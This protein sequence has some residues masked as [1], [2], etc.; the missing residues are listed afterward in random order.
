MSK[1]VLIA[2]G[3][4]LLAAPALAFDGSRKG[5]ILGVGAGGGATSF[6]QE[7][8]GF[9]T[10]K[11]ETET[12][13]AFATDFELGWG[14]NDQLLIYYSNHV[15]WFGITNVFN[16]SVT[17]AS[18][19]SSAAV[20]YFFKPAAPSAVVEGGIGGAGWNALS[21]GQSSSSVGLGVWAGGGY[22]FSRHW[23]VRGKITYGKPSD[24]QGGVK[25]ETTATGFGVTVNYLAY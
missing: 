23:L 22:E 1:H 25:L 12:K 15:H 6:K 2:L 5:F 19:V 14:A 24:D 4:L 9:A 10:G 18:G 8:S 11:T 17:I 16:N 7:L 13:G 21:G 20:S 3:L